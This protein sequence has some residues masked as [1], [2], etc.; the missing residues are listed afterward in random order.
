MAPR[1]AKHQDRRE[2]QEEL[3]APAYG[4][5]RRSSKPLRAWFSRN[6]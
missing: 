5:R 1:G 2:D 3:P 4:A 6:R